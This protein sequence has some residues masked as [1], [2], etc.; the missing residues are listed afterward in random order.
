MKNIFYTA[1]IIF[2]LMMSPIFAVAQVAPGDLDTTFNGT[3]KSRV[4][5]PGDDNGSALAVQADGKRVVAGYSLDGAKSAFLVIR[6][7]T[8]GSP[9]TSFGIGGKVLTDVGSNGGEAK[10]VKIQADGKIVVAGDSVNSTNG[11]FPNRFTIVR[12]NS[13]GS[14]DM[15]FGSGGKVITVVGAHTAEA[16]GLAIQTDGKL[17]VV[18]TA[19]NNSSD[20]DFAVVR[21]N[22]DGS[23]DVSFNVDGIALTPIEGNDKAHAVTIQSDDKIVAAG[24]ASGGSGS[25][26]AVVRYNSNGSL[27]NSFDLDGK[28]ITPIG[29][30]SGNSVANAVAI[31]LGNNAQ[32]D[33]IVVVGDQIA[34]ND[35]AVARYNSN[36][37]LDTTFDSDGKL[38]IDIRGFS[39]SCKA[40]SV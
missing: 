24:Y 31:Q 32:P 15:S 6:Y 25:H 9:D 36:G 28:T 7:N 38:T 21:Y 26:F 4:A 35:C 30:G 19:V 23:L 5:L 16:Y 37:S 8:D 18:G 29:I 3:G 14:L 11:F 22:S 13:D 27:D 20:N 34:S 40:V 12:Y 17:V 1:V 2:S 39:D 33:K 10:A